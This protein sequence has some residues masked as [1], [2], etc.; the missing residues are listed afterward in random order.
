MKAKLELVLDE[1]ALKEH[2][3]N[4]EPGDVLEFTMSVTVA[5]LLEV[6]EEKAVLEL[7]EIV[8]DKFSVIEEALE[9]DEDD[10]EE[11]IAFADI[12]A[13]TNTDL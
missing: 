6:T 7:D 4:R 8:F 1:E 10:E 13:A 11:P 9:E 12:G 2:F 5:D 3:K